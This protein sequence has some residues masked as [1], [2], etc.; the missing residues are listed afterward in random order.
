MDDGNVPIKEVESR[1]LPSLLQAIP[2]VDHSRDLQVRSSLRNDGRIDY[3]RG[4]AWQQL[5]LNRRLQRRRRDEQSETASRSIGDRD[6]VLLFEHDH[7]YT[8]G[9]GADENYITFLASDDEVPHNQTPSGHR[10]RAVDARHRLSRRS[11][12]PGSARLAVDTTNHWIEGSHQQYTD[13][14]MVNQWSR[15]ATPVVAPNGAPIYR[16]E[17]GGEVTYHGPGQLVVYPL[18]DLQREPFRKDLHWYL[19]MIEEV[20]IRTLKQY[21]IDSTRDSANTGVWVGHDKVAAVGVSSS[22]WITTHGFAMN[23]NPDLSYFDTSV[24]LPC[25]IAGKG[26]TSIAKLLSDSGEECFPTVEEV[27]NVVLRKIE[28]VF[29]VNVEIVDSIG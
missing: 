23:V 29:S 2:T 27:S 7:V 11:R 12:G 10:D 8:L 16:V 26:V 6:T 15:M 3:V 25:G 17:R 28:D 13:H 14:E 4:W 21:G 22:R 1:G 5:I 9:R 19:R 18:F 24:I 20:I